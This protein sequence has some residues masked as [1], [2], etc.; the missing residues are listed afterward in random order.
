MQMRDMSRVYTYSYFTP[1]IKAHYGLDDR[2]HL[3][4]DPD[5]RALFYLVRRSV[6]KDEAFAGQ[7]PRWAIDQKTLEWMVK[8]DNY[9]RVT[10]AY[11]LLVESYRAQLPPVY[12]T[13]AREMLK[14][15]D[16]IPPVYNVDNSYWWVDERGEPLYSGSMLGPA[17]DRPPF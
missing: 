17:L 15:L 5:T 7:P 6:P 10:V 8:Q 16:R 12:Y 1:E 2:R 14:K 13:T 3:R 4:W 11:V 9:E